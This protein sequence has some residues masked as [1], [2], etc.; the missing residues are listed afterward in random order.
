MALAAEGLIIA[1]GGKTYLP[2]GSIGI[3][4]DALDVYERVLSQY[5]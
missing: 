1:N 5:E 2:Y 3:I 4:D